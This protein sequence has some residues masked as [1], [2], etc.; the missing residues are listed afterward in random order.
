MFELSLIERATRDLEWA[1]RSPLLS[2]E[3]PPG[4]SELVSQSSTLPL[5][6]NDTASRRHP[7]IGRYF[8]R[9]LAHWLGA[10]E[11]VS[12]L[13]CNLPV[14]EGKRTLGE[15]DLIFRLG[16]TWYHWELAIKF[17]LG[18][19]QL[20]STENWHG[21]LGRDRLDIKLNRLHA[22]QLKLLE[23]DT[24]RT[25]LVDRG[26]PE[27]SSH[28]VLKGYLFHPLD[29]WLAKRFTVP[30]EINPGHGNGFWAHLAEIEKVVK[31]SCKWVL[32]PKADWLAPAQSTQAMPST[33]FKTAIHSYFSTD[34][35]PPL[36]AAIDDKGQEIARV[37]IVPNNWAPCPTRRHPY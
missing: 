17:Y 18:V 14:Q 7:P 12:E 28:M 21:P 15:L 31:L 29:A 25:L 3:T 5:P 8:E 10:Q 30:K 35:R 19:G 23:T 36:I 33:D 2:S 32:L 13:E 34:S 24:G 37:F 20:E 9:L 6:D 27:I 22:H 26:I 1:V 16:D 11:S 4:Y